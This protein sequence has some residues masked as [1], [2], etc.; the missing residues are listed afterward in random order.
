MKLYPQCKS[1]LAESRILKEQSQNRRV[2]IYKLQ[3]GQQGSY[4]RRKRCYGWELTAMLIS[5][6]NTLV[7]KLN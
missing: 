4:G 2:V 5:A 3:K 1:F 6:P 7:S